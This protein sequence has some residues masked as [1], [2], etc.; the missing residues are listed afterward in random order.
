MFTTENF[1]LR[2]YLESRSIKFW[3]AGRNVAPGWYGIRC[4]FCDDTHNHLGINLESKNFHCWR[5]GSKG[6][7]LK[8]IRELEDITPKAARKIAIEFSDK[9]E[10]RKILSKPEP[11]F[12][13]KIIYPKLCDP[14]PIHYEYLKKRR[15]DLDKMQKKYDL[16][17]TGMTAESGWKMRI[18]L[19]IKMQNVIQTYTSVDVTGKAEFKYRSAGPEKSFLPAKSTL[20]GVDWIKSST[21]IVEGPFDQWRL[22]DGAIA[23]LGVQITAGQLLIL[24]KLACENYYVLFDGETQAILRAHKL[25]E[26]LNLLGKN[27]EILELNSGDPDDFTDEWV[28]NLKKELKI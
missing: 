7:I 3:E 17:F 15:Y 13:N 27:V 21:I 24:S 23:T 19:P 25:A 11:Q 16:K 14:L 20:Y 10:F 8:L 6:G 26:Q 5:C 1:N 12:N 18:I 28:A 22:G 2:Q 9:T 4:V